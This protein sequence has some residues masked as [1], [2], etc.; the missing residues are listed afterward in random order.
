[1]TL[2]KNPT[3]FPFLTIKGTQLA[4]FLHFLLLL[5]LQC[6]TYVHSSLLLHHSII[7]WFTEST[8]YVNI[9]VG[10]A[11]VQTHLILDFQLYFFFHYSI[12]YLAIYIISCYFIFF[13]ITNRTVSLDAFNPILEVSYRVQTDFQLCTYITGDS[14]IAYVYYRQHISI[15]LTSIYLITYLSRLRKQEPISMIK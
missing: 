13:P 12:T 10:S 6:S 8:F 14:L 15:S 1:M 3:Y 11:S 2:E 7:L 9:L 5:L 4:I